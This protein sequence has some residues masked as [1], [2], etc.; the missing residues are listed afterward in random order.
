MYHALSKPSGGLPLCE[1]RLR[2]SGCGGGRWEVGGWR[3]G[4]G[5]GGESREAKLWPVCKI[6]EKVLIKKRIVIS[7][8]I[9]L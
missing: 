6:S 1:W 4:E 3:G 7:K 2:R 9:S 8:I 5:R